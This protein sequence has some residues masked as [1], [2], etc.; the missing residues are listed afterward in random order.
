M[1]EGTL[2]SSAAPSDGVVADAELQP[3]TLVARH[4][5]ID[6]GIWERLG[7]HLRAVGERAERSAAVFGA[8]PWGR[9]LGRWHD[10]GKASAEFQA[11]IRRSV[12]G[13]PTG[14]V[15]HSTAAAQLAAP[16]GPP[17]RLLAPLL[18]GHHGGLPD[19]A[20]M[21]GAAGRLAKDIPSW[22][23]NAELHL[24]DLLDDGGLA[25]WDLPFDL[26]AIESERRGFALATLGRMLFSALVDADSLVSERLAHPDREQT[27]Q[28]VAVERVGETFDAAMESFAASA[29]PSQLNRTRAE[30]LAA[31]RKAAASERG[32]FSL[33][34]PTGGGKTFASLAFALDHIRHSATQG[35]DGPPL[36]G[37]VYAIPYTSIIDQTADSFRRL[38]GPLGD[39]A[40][41]EH[42]G[43]V[44]RERDTKKGEKDEPHPLDLAA[45]NFDHP[46]VVTTNVQLLESLFAAERSRCRKLHN[47]TGRVLVFDE[48][49]TLP[50]RLLKPTLLMLRELVE[51]YG[52]QS[53]RSRRAFVLNQRLRVARLGMT[54]LDVRHCELL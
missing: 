34:V 22:Q 5:E 16:H 32:F 15:D 30:I 17:G 37:V 35:G 42:H 45:E 25:G 26:K 1:T 50:L 8:A 3:E 7:D 39:E 19:A 14:T 12:A 51:R 36:R 40:V 43:Q 28:P 21:S 13:Q 29:E 31:C 11:Y 4:A 10:L 54:G 38:L 6:G 53:L 41:L 44:I 24:A 47:L 27:R 20:A 46:L 23:A 33:T 18:A 48:A 9:L 49:Q 2:R 52:C